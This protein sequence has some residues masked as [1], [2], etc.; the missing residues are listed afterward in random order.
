[1]IFYKAEWKV[2]N[3]DNLGTFG[4]IYVIAKDAMEAIN[5]VIVFEK[6]CGF[7]VIISSLDIIEETNKVSRYEGVIY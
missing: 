4:I 5:K 7:D 3:L 1:M 2:K 6:H